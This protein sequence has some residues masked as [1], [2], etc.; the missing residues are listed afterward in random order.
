MDSN[1]RR[2]RR[3]HRSP[4]RCESESDKQLRDTSALEENCFQNGDHHTKEVVHDSEAPREECLEP[5]TVPVFACELQ[6]GD[7]HVQSKADSSSVLQSRIIRVMRRRFKELIVIV[8]L[9]V[10]VFAAVKSSSLKTQKAAPPS[11]F[12]NDPSSLV[13][14]YEFGSL[15]ELSN[16]ALNSDV[17][18]I[19][20]YAP[21]DADSIRFKKE[22]EIVAKH[23]T[24]EVFFAAIN[25]W[26][27]EGECVKQFNIK[28]F[29]VLV[30]NVRNAGDVEYN[31]PSLASY[32]IPFIDN[33]LNPVIH[34]LNDGDLLDLRSKHDAV[35]VGYFDFNQF[36]EPQGYNQYFTASVKSLM[37][38]PWRRV[39]FTVITSRQ[40]AHKL[41]M[42]SHSSITLYLWNSTS[43]FTGNIKNV[44]TLVNWIYGSLG[45]EN[46][47]QVEW[48]TPTGIKSLSLSTILTQS[49]TFIL[50]TPRSLI[51]DISPYFD[52]LREVAFDYFNCDKSPTIRSII[53]RSILRRHLMEEKLMD[54]EEKCHEL[55]NPQTYN[56]AALAWNTAA[57]I[58][59]DTC[60]HSQIVHW[61]PHGKPADKKCYCTSCIHISLAKC[62]GGCKRFN[63]LATASRYLSTFNP[64]D[65]NSTAS[66]CN[67]I[68]SNYQ[69]KFTPYYRV[70]TSCSGKTPEDDGYRLSGGED[71]M[72][73]TTYGASGLSSSV[74]QHRD[75]KV[76]RMIQNF[77][78][79]YCKRLHLGLNYSDLNFP[80]SGEG[81]DGV[82]VGSQSWRSNFT[83][84]ACH[85]NRT[86]KFIAMDSIL[87]PSF[88]ENLGIDVFNETHATVAVIVESKNENIYLLNHELASSTA[89]TSTINKRV[90]YEFIKNYTN[91]NLRRFL[92]SSFSNRISSSESC[93]SEVGDQGVVCVPEVTSSN[94]EE[95]VLDSRRDVL[96][97]YY[98]PWCGFCTSVAHIY[99]SVAKYFFGVQE[100]LFARINGDTN[101]LP[102]EYTVDMYPSLIFFPAKRKA[103]SVTFPSKSRITT[104]SLL[105]FVLD[106][107]QTIV[108]WKMSLVLCNRQ[109]LLKNLAAY[110]TQVRSLQRSV[111]SDM[112]KIRFV[113][114][115]TSEIEMKSMQAQGV[116]EFINY[117][118]NSIKTKRRKLRLMSKLQDLLKKRLKNFNDTPH[119]LF[120]SM[121]NTNTKEVK[122]DDLS[123]KAKKKKNKK[124]NSEIGK[125]TAHKDE[126]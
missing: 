55:S 28:R 2:R 26:W 122:N 63:C 108:K 80:D 51:L 83:G 39:Q 109:C 99:L 34:L 96:L 84:L 13:T 17:S 12:F 71:S 112:L 65:V 47:T 82:T 105:K 85:T 107:A 115:E 77:E 58:E 42:N 9:S 90:I 18:F 60:C 111:Q 81:S 49:S 7:N 56:P 100:I 62:P 64:S 27:P 33:L 125:K 67:E 86:L 72:Y 57:Q 116:T 102:F 75:E 31:G 4:N 59:G 94:F 89:T 41:S 35:V 30:A 87:F 101:A 21:W 44:E 66:Y 8:F 103:E 1:S 24:D 69:P 79:Q 40:L 117:L 118:I 106:N 73:S 70:V 25:C 54:L 10:T 95:I 68:R 19:M 48:I 121:L 23:Y 38:D 52:V 113:R 22:Y 37:L 32:I 3:V 16:R 45:Q 123:K 104:S 93:M 88:A 5:S 15:T 43:V 11:K 120:E 98:A 14:D 110:S 114:Q 91:T 53:H 92:K 50:F 124:S 20:Y 126:L 6:N 97:M 119:D 61:R 74:H 78:E 76:E 46:R 29:P 36:S